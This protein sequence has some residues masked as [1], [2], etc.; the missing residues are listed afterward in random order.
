[1]RTIKFLFAIVTVL[2]GAFLLL[3]AHGVSVAIQEREQGW[4]ITPLPTNPVAHMVAYA[5][6]GI[7]L[8]FLAAWLLIP[9][10]LERG[11]RA[12][13]GRYSATVGF[14]I[15]AGVVAAFV[16]LFL[17]QALLDSGTI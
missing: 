10:S 6:G 17:L 3:S 11:T 2:T 12:F 8:Q 13:W 4:A 15:F 1:V 16:I 5:T 7:A 9:D 14:C